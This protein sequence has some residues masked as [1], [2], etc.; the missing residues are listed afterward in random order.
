MPATVNVCAEL[1]NGA[2]VVTP[3]PTATA[4]CVWSAYSSS[5]VTD[6][7]ARCNCSTIRRPMPRSPQTITCPTGP[8][9]ARAL[10]TALSVDTGGPPFDADP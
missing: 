5:T 7:P 4:S 2:T 6:S 8:A 10:S 9:S 1:P 3:Q